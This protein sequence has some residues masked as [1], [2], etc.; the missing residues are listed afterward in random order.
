MKKSVV[1]FVEAFRAEGFTDLLDVPEDRITQFCNDSNYSFKPV[2]KRLR[3]NNRSSQVLN[4]H[5]AID[6]SLSIFLE[7]QFLVNATINTD[8][9]AFG[10]KA[11]FL[12]SLGQLSEDNYVWVVKLNRLRNKLAHTL[13]FKISD[14]TVKE[15]TTHIKGIKEKA[16]E[17]EEGTQLFGDALLILIFLVE[18]DRWRQ[19]HISVKAYLAMLNA[20]KVLNDV[21]PDRHPRRLGE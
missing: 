15:F 9:L 11:D 16:G 20:R 2:A 14:S 1:E 12:Y 8:R 3:L 13:D 10:Q 18:A 17:K 21:S 19:R 7:D 6:H 5:L 4:A